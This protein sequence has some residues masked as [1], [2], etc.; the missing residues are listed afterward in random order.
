VQPL[1]TLTAGQVERWRLVHAGIGD[2]VTVR[3]ARLK[4]GT[5]VPAAGVAAAQEE[6]F[7]RASCDDASQPLFEIQADGLTRA[8]VAPV[9]LDTLQ[10]GYR[11]DLLVAV[12]E[13][14]RYCLLDMEAPATSE[15]AKRRRGI[16]EGTRL[17]GIVRVLPMTSFVPHRTIPEAEITI[18]EPQRVVFDVVGKTSP[19][20][21]DIDPYYYYID[22]KSYDPEV[23]N[24]VLPLGGVQEWRLSS[25]NF[26]HPFHIHVNPFQVVGIFALAADGTRTDVT[27]PAIPYAQRLAA[28]GDDPQYLGLRGVWKDTLFVMPGFDIVTRTR[29]QR[30]IGEFVLHC[31]ILDHEDR[32]M[33]QNVSIVPPGAVPTGRKTVGHSH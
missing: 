1:I 28:A 33:M 30:Y 7:T 23:V 6:A 17:L 8:Q 21:G 12:P 24:R 22:G 10:P 25:R 16:P 31:H 13:P 15:A 9:M 5:T 4:P 2:T 18:P 11:S 32:G 20:P 26:S 19:Q 29:Y 27:D 14:G 3:L